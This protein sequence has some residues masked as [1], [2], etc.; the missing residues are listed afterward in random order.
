MNPI[1]RNIFQTIKDFSLIIVLIHYLFGFVNYSYI[2]GYVLILIISRKS[3]QLCT[4]IINACN[5]PSHKRLHSNP[6]TAKSAAIP[7]YVYKL[8]DRKANKPKSSKATCSYII[9][10]QKPQKYHHR[11]IYAPPQLCA[12]LAQLA[13][14]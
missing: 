9:W 11:R 8:M 10:G 14:A 1:I 7:P 4:T 2:K 12:D 5:K 6:E 3:S 13:A